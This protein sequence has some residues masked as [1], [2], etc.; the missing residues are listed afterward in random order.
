MLKHV[1]TIF[2]IALSAMCFAQKEHYYILFSAR[3]A[4]LF[5]FS[6]GGHAFITWRSED[7]LQQKAEQFTYGFFA[8]KGNGM[9]K[10]TEGVVVEGYV[11]NSNRERF[12][13]RFIIELD[14]QSYHE[15]LK[16][17]ESWN[18][19]PYNLFDNNCVH[20]MDQIARK[21]GLKTPKTKSCIFPR[22]P[23]VYIKKLKKMNKAR[24]VS[25]ESLEKARL[26]ILRKAEV[27]VEDDDDDDK[28]N[29]GVK[30]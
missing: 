25:N 28:P 16:I 5:P 26:K 17:V 10:N 15:T 22:K 20:F 8:K 7:T 4:S 14:S 9:F 12:V 6:I 23:S 1:F 27:E 19:E 2:F 29:S 21:L 24:I 11:K 30:N 18:A 13:R 3:F